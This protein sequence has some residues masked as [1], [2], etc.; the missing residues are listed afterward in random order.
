M[1]N[2]S[3]ITF[4][5]IGYSPVIQISLNIWQDSSA[6]ILQM[7]KG[8]IRR[9][10]CFKIKDRYSFH[11]NHLLYAHRR[12]SSLIIQEINIQ[13][14]SDQTLNV[15]FIQNKQTSNF[16][17]RQLHQQDIQFD[18]SKDRFEMVTYQI[19]VR[20]QHSIICV[21]I[22]KKIISNQRIK[23]ARYIEYSIKSSY[24]SS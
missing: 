20:K 14:P 12:R 7:N 19:L 15:N 1:P 22:S 21:I 9:F 4:I 16:D 18:S 8:L 17:L 2:I 6:T 10:Q 24:F 23:P 3:G 5:P 11:V 13:N